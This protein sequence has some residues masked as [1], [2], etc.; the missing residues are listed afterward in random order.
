[1][2]ILS[3]PYCDDACAPVPNWIAPVAEGL[4]FFSFVSSA[5]FIPPL[6]TGLLELAVGVLSKVR[7]SCLP[8]TSVER[9]P[10]VEQAAACRA[11]KD[12]TVGTPV[13]VVDARHR[14][15]AARAQMPERQT[16]TA[17][18]CRLLLVYLQ[19][20]TRLHSQ[21]PT[22][23]AAPVKAVAPQA[24]RR[25]QL[26]GRRRI[27]RRVLVKR[28]HVEDHVTNRHRKRQRRARERRGTGYDPVIYVLLSDNVKCVGYAA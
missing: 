26:R 3:I 22:D 13:I 28:R 2:A 24:N 20:Q 8:S 23:I 7:A 16:V 25:R 14:R 27:A 4:F 10:I 15:I 18:R 17:C 9:S 1:M 5:V 19:A 11:D 12:V 21:R 6:V